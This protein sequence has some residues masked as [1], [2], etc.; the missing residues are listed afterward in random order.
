L[1]S[2]PEILDSLKEQLQIIDPRISNMHFMSLPFMSAEEFDY[3]NIAEE[4]NLLQPDIIWVSL[5]A[6]KQEKFMYYILPK[7]KQGIMFGFGAILNF[8]SGM[9]NL[10]EPLKSC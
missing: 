6:P 3:N 7:L 4:I 5:G 2:T 8:Y 10:K 9:K 1:G